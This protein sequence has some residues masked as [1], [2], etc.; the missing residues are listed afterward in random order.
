ML[1]LK[2]ACVFVVATAVCAVPVR[3]LAQDAT[4]PG[5]EST[6]AE[7]STRASD[8]YDLRYAARPL[9]MP[10]GMVRGTFDVSGFRFT[11]F[12]F[13]ETFWS[14]NFGIAI[15]PVKHLEIGFSRYR[16]GGFPGINSIDLFGLGGQG[17]IS[18][19]VAPEGEFGDIP[20]YVRYQPLEGVADLALELRLRIPT[21]SEFGMAFGVP[22]RLHAGD[23]VAIDTGF[24]LTYDA[25]STAR[26]LS[27]G[28]PLDLVVN[29][30]R[31]VFLKVQSGVSLPDI[32]TAPVVAGFPLGFVLGGSAPAGSTMLDVFVS[33][34]FPIFGVVGSGGGELTT[35]IWALTF[36]INVHSPLLF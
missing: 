13:S 18:A 17:L 6:E 11:F 15:A 28:F 8:N 30:S 9:T 23:W 22:L 4:E 26:L 29:A 7:P 34:R 21:F 16:M 3:A 31:N 36:G 19:F 20:F 10:K 35:E 24:D 5:I 2:F 25:P 33:F 32:T 14:L 1:E 12:G 27:I